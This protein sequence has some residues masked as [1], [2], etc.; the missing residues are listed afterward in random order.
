MDKGLCAI[1]ELGD[2]YKISLQSQFLLEQKYNCKH[3]I[4]KSNRNED[5]ILN[6]FCNEKNKLM[7]FNNIF[8]L[9]WK[10]NKDSYMFDIVYFQTFL[11]HEPNRYR[12]FVLLFLLINRKKVVVAIRNGFSYL[13]NKVKTYLES[14]KPL[15]K[16]KFKNFHIQFRQYLRVWFNYLMLPLYQ[17]CVF[18]SRTQM[19]F[20]KKNLRAQYKLKYGVV[21]DKYSLENKNITP[22]I[23]IYKNKIMIGL[24]GGVNSQRRDYKVLLDALKI[25]DKELREKI[26]FTIL[27]HTY[28][29]E[30][31]KI[32]DG[33]RNFVD[34]VTI[35]SFLSEEEFKFYGK[36]CSF[37]L[38]PLKN[39]KPY[40]TLAGTG[41]FGD[42]IFLS[43]TIILPMKVDPLQEFGKFCL[44][45][46]DINGLKNIFENI[47]K[48]KKSGIIEYEDLRNFSKEKVL[49]DL[50]DNGII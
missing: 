33:L 23:D 29:K 39:D 43:R 44:Y 49:Q 14:Y 36:G 8:S 38:S 7:K 16:S 30:A 27:G 19:I 45:Y 2:H 3:Y 15:N 48:N 20:F 24:L 13:P 12:V 47:I 37:L 40:G 18:E 11:D 31:P 6:S 25:L 35:N 32:I 34:V 50:E 5:A 4:L 41:S 10:L 22:K 21:F 1:V 26:S 9:L 46:N 28:C 17:S 42:F